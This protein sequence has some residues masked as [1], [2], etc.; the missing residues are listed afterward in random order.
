[1]RAGAAMVAALAAGAAGIA[2]EAT[3]P[4]A[5]ADAPEPSAGSAVPALLRVPY[6][7]PAGAA[8]L[9]E[10]LIAAGFRA[11]F[12]C[13]AHFHARRPLED[14]IAVELADT[15]R[16]GLPAPSID[17]ERFLATAGDGNGRL[18][19][20]A[21]RKSLGCTLLPPDQGSAG[22]AR[23]PHVE[24]APAPDLAD[25]P[26]PV[27]DKV[28]LGAEGAVLQGRR[29][30]PVAERA[31]DTQSYVAGKLTTGLLVVH[32]GR[33]I[34]ERY[35]PLFDIASGYR[36]WSTTKTI[37]AA[38]IG[39]A[40]GD[41]LLDPDAPAPVP[42]WQTPGDP[43]A[44]VTLRHLMWMSSGLRSE[45]SNT[46]A[47]YFGGQDVIS[48]ATTT[49]LEA[50]PGTRWK[51]AN[52]D[53]L[54]LLRS[55][56]AVLDDDLAYLRYPYDRLLRRIGMY[57]TRMETDHDGNFIGSSQTY[58]T[59]RD[60]A[61]FGLLLLADGVWEGER[62]LPEGWVDFLT[63]PAP[64][65]PAVQGER[66]YGAQVWLL[67]TLPGVPPGTYTTAGN[68][69]QYV[70]VVPTHDLVIVRTGV[71]PRGVRFP[72]DRLVADIV[73]ALER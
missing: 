24:F 22:V 2:S 44:A 20:A 51:Y 43:R 73:E 10:P 57:H 16:L 11:L 52:N 17:A 7:R 31:F 14:I 63:E 50:P 4:A 58:T 25:V 56:R 54:L 59:A 41:G 34:L 21:Y 65:R 37:T 36:T 3:A 62:I 67:G 30:L 40:V 18:R 60:L 29:L 64:A 42:E 39:I 9:D 48:A 6:F 5:R 15:R 12:T 28:R 69:G 68:K 35:R 71:D 70:T 23:L 19:V 45:G 53:T 72:Q 33:L 55:L 49:E 61:R 13:S 47:I 38:I 1:M 26:F 32:E 8:G 27:G 46:N 66:G